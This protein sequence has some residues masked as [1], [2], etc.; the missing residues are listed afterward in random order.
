MVVIASVAFVLGVLAFYASQK[1]R[2][3]KDLLE[4]KNREL[5]KRLYEI[6]V[7]QTIPRVSIFPKV[8]CP[9][10]GVFL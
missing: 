10:N 7:S 8:K 9:S 3:T 2:H 5:E 4:K 6:S 1:L